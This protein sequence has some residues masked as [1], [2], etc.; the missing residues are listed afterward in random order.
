MIHQTD[1][2]I[3][4]IH[5]IQRD[6]LSICLINPTTLQSISRNVLLQL[7]E[8]YEF[9][10]GTKTDKIY[11]DYELVQVSVIGD[12]HSMKLNVNVPLKTANSQFTLYKVVV[13]PNRVS[14]SNFVKYTVDYS[15]FG[16]ESSRHD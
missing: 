4:A 10:V 2:L 15:S 9:I 7:P 5:C 13:L 11:L 8:G 16:L 1:E 14:K 6:K 3:G 12:V